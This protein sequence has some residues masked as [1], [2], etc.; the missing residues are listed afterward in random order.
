MTGSNPRHVGMEPWLAMP[1]STR[2]RAEAR[3]A[4]FACVVTA[5]AD[6]ADAL[7]L[8]AGELGGILGISEGEWLVLLHR[9]P[10]VAASEWLDTSLRLLCELLGSVLTFAE[11]TDGAWW[12]RAHH[13]AMGDSPL[14]R[15][16]RSPMALPWLSAILL[17][18]RGR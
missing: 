17:E 14:G 12:L 5:V 13:P 7:G 9:W 1:A 2:A 10:H 11:K 3:D 4:P 16:I 8:S 15:L 6:R 18:E